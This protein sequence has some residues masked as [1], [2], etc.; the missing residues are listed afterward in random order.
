MKIR[1]L[2]VLCVLAQAAVFSKGTGSVEGFD[3]LRTDLGA[4]PVSMGGAFGSVKSDLYGMR[5]N[6]ASLFGVRDLAVT[7]SYLDQILDIKSGFI[8]LN[9]VLTENSQIGFAIAYIDYGEL[10]KR[11]VNG[12]D[13]GTFY[14]G[15]F[16]FSSTYAG[17]FN[18]GL[19][20]GVTAKFISSH[21]DNYSASAFAADAGL[22]Y[23]LEK[24][25]INFGLSLQNIGKSVNSYVDSVEI[26]PSLFRF[27]ISKGLAH[28]PLVL[29]FNIYRFFH[30]K[31]NIVGGIYWALGGE[32]TIKENFFLRFGYN[33]KGR[34][35]KLGAANDSFAGISFGVGLKY[36]KYC[37][38]YGFNSLGGLG[39]MNCLTVTFDI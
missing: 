4:R 22:L 1:Y 26:L 19:V 17:R 29:N 30:N 24:K 37:F 35:Q 27:G 33:S 21:I 5:Y 28:L 10:R 25:K 15:D 3:F 31:S 20:Y 2:I 12:E 23:S 36:R 39:S 16:I 18:F 8:G 13:L 11:D 14:C 6:P 32:F 9:K 38:D 7:F 34:E